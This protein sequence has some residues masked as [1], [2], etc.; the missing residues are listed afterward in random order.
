MLEP[1]QL[2]KWQFVGWYGGRSGAKS[3]TLSRVAVLLGTQRPLRIVGCREIQDSVDHSMKQLCEDSIAA[4]ELEDYYRIYSRSIVGTNG[5]EIIFRGLSKDTERTIKSFEGVDICWLE[6]AQDI[7]ESS[8]RL[9]VPTVRKPGSQIWVSFNPRSRA[10]IVYREFVSERTRPRMF[11]RKVNYVD[12]P[13]LSEESIA[14]AEHARIHEP[15][16]YRHIWLGEPEP[17]IG[18][19]RVLL[20]RD[21]ENAIKAYPQYASLIEGRKPDIGLDIADL[22]DDLNAMATRYGPLLT[23]L[24]VWRG[25]QS[26]N[27]TARRAHNHATREGAVNLYYDASG[28]GSSIRSFLYEAGRLAYIDTGVQFGGAVAGGDVY[29]DT[30]LLNKHAFAMRKDQMAWAVKRRLERTTQL[31]EGESVDPADCLFINPDIVESNDTKGLREQLNQPVWDDRDGGKIRIDKNP[32]DVKSPD[33]FDALCLAF[34]EDSRRGL[35]VG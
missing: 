30:H 35:R 18:I 24:E 12:N 34:C 28:I 15:E 23:S 10:D 11:V 1:D 9:L 26:L 17:D 22:G 33:M 7:P 14:Q 29:Y 27:D 6:E 31:L 3:T 2:S 4:L 20:M 25:S 19:R 5:T 8:W 13:F 21:I 16:F 32:D